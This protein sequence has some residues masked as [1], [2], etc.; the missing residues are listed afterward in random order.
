[1][2]IA[3]PLGFKFHGQGLSL[4]GA[5]LGNFVVCPKKV[6]RRQGEVIPFACDLE[7]RTT[8]QTMSFDRIPFRELTE[9]WWKN[10]PP[11]CWYDTQK[12]RPDREMQRLFQACIASASQVDIVQPEKIGWTKLPSGKMAYITGDQVIGSAPEDTFLVWPPE[13]AEELVF[14]E[15]PASS[16]EDAVAYF[17]DLFHT[18]PGITDVLM[19]YTLFSFLSPLFREAGLTSR[20][21]IVLEGATESKKTTLAALTCGAFRRKTNPHNCMVGLTSSRSAV[22]L[23]AGQMRHCTLIVDDLFPDGGRSQQEK[24]LNLIRD[25]ANQDAR[26]IKLGKSIVGNR[27]DCG[28]VITAE[29]FPPC[30]RSTRTRCLRLKLRERIPNMVI[31]PFQ[32]SP[33]LLSKFFEAYLERISKNYQVLTDKVAKDLQ[34][35]RK[36]RA[37]DLSNLISSERLS[38]IGFMLYETLDLLF[39]IFPDQSKEDCLNCFQEEVNQ[40]IAWQ[41]SPEAVPE[42]RDI[43]SSIPL[44]YQQYP[45][46][47]RE[48]RGCWCITPDALCQ[49]LQVHY[50]DPTIDRAYVIQ[51][52]QRRMVLKKDQ[53]GAATKK[54]AGQRYL[55]LIP[56]RLWES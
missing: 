30:E 47:F 53:S 33:A 9:E 6:Y 14:E 26:E 39:T 48:H 34:E 29:F 3:L 18:I 17:W 50:Q 45:E 56:H 32:E 20:F 37:C 27:L 36:Q 10:P 35:Y 19:V 21:P 31:Y 23:R 16:L 54:I 22:E 28:M 51:C 13:H 55:H 52:L 12:R 43:V 5:N 15:E 11:G 4:D 42:L 38:E 49:L 1:M 8:E 25:F 24:A 46:Q 44:L 41:L 2:D 7:I 40:W